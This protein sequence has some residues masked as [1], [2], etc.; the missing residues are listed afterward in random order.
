MVKKSRDKDKHNI[1][2]LKEFIGIIRVDW[3]YV[4]L[5]F[6]G[7]LLTTV[8]YVLNARN[9]YESTTVIKIT[10]PQG[11]ILTSSPIPEFQDFGS[12]SDR[13]ISN[14]IELLNR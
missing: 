6:L 2:I 8:F 12:L 5:I 10:K 1:D 9:I 11:S 4:L 13:Y 3:I 7:V 14:E